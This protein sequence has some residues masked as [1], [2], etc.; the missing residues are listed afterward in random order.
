[1]VVG[2]LTLELLIP[3][4]H[5]LKGKRAAIRPLISN[6]RQDFACSVA[7]VADQDSWQRATLGVA[8]VSSDRRHADSVLAAVLNRAVE[9]SGDAVAGSSHIELIELG[10]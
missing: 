8:V 7:E 10:G 9:W 3:D 6:L 5:S 1:M 4:N 2:V